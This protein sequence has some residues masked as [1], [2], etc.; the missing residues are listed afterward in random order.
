MTISLSTENVFYCFE[1]LGDITI[2]SDITPTNYFMSCRVPTT[3]KIKRKISKSLAANGSS[4]TAASR[5]RIGYDHGPCLRLAAPS[6]T[7]TLSFTCT[8]S[9]WI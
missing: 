7:G 1:D 2:L 8:R 5:N 4:N 9:T 3:S 6:H